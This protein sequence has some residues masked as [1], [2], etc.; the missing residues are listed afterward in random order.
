MSSQANTGQD[1]RADAGQA[2]AAGKADMP[3]FGRTNG[4]YET[5]E[6]FGSP[7][8]QEFAASVHLPAAVEGPLRQADTLMRDQGL[9][10][11]L[12]AYVQAI[13][14]ADRIDQ[15]KIAQKLT[16]I[17]Q[18]KQLVTDPHQLQ[19]YRQ[20]GAELLVQALAPAATRANLGLALL[21]SGQIDQG[22]AMLNEAA[23]L[24]PGLQNDPRFLRRLESAM[25]DAQALAVKQEMP[26]AVAQN[27]D[28]GRY[29]A[30]AGAPEAIR[31]AAAGTTSA[32]LND[33][34]GITPAKASATSQFAR[35]GA[36]SETAAASGGDT[37]R[38]R[39]ASGEQGSDVPASVQLA[40]AAAQ[41][42]EQASDKRAGLTKLEPQFRNAI[43]QADVQFDQ[44]IAKSQSVMTA[45]SKVLTPEAG[46]QVEE[47]QAKVAVAVQ[48]LPEADQRLA[49]KVL[50]GAAG[51]SERISA[52]NT[53]AGKHPEVVPT[54]KAGLE[55]QAALMPQ[56]T[57]A[58]QAQEIVQQAL[59][60]SVLTRSVYAEALQ[61][62][63]M[64]N[65]A[66]KIMTE[67]L[68]IV[69]PEL[70][71]AY[72]QELAP[73][74]QKIGIT[75]TGTDA[76]QSGKA[77][78]DKA[79]IQQ[80]V[81]TP[82]T[83]S[84]AAKSGRRSGGA[85]AQEVVYRPKEGDRAQKL[86]ELP[87]D[88]QTR[89]AVYRPGVD[90][91]PR[92]TNANLT[93]QPVRSEKLPDS[94]AVQAASAGSDFIAAMQKFEAAGNKA[95][96]MKTLSGE[97]QAAI[98]QVDKEL[99]AD[100][101]TI[102]AKFEAAVA[103]LQKAQTPEM[104]KTLQAFAEQAKKDQ[105]QLS[106]TELTSIMTAGD[107]KTGAG[108]RQAALNALAVKH[109][110][111]SALL[112]KRVEIE[113]A[114]APQ[115]AAVQQIEALAKEEMSGPV[116]LRAIYASAQNDAGMRDAA[117]STMNE[118]LSKMPVELWPEM[119][120][121]LTPIM[122]KLGIPVPGENAT[123]T[124]QAAAGIQPPEDCPMPPSR[125]NPK[126][127]RARSSWYEQWIQ[128]DNIPRCWRWSLRTL[129]KSFG[130]WVVRILDRDSTRP[131]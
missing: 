4:F 12:P 39:Q 91:Q 6:R 50:D 30:P 94:R 69:P 25:Q 34:S 61:E 90:E 52:L 65:E 89:T 127:T 62:A 37:A 122:R 16:Q 119:A 40:A 3:D 72:A 33:R 20:L 51:D 79:P 38:V 59:Q 98:A 131:R 110:E 29:A 73:L 85:Q 68:S 24:N 31:A 77:L 74:L 2:D 83:Q 97:F 130:P 14:A 67:A 71:Q 111:L 21:R 80:A 88:P 55:M 82:D 64:K 108:D 19:A 118:A 103:A 26:Q 70:R 9:Q 66:V 60:A 11:A 49:E 124:A 107:P 53:L 112:S 113:A 101:P 125:G 120:E 96:A 126:R 54:L 22:M 81:Y 86:A 102:K 57:A 36:A 87:T 100:M 41:E 76:G 5:A 17:E 117:I 27:V 15:S 105:A 44:V 104:Q 1:G 7:K 109:P 8:M 47:L 95:E 58:A 46:K 115:I 93:D 35:A 92:L 28:A 18:Q 84:E 23:T 116:L 10:A 48:K 129:Q 121:G 106:Q 43:T 32:A 42:F 13:Q 99:A 128:K 123:Q 63:G 45:L 114:L 56:L 75:A 78:P